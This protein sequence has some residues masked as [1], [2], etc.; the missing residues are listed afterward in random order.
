MLR[1]SS[2]LPTKWPGFRS[3]DLR[4]LSEMA[5]TLLSYTSQAP[6]IFTQGLETAE[7]K[8]EAETHLA[9]SKANF[10]SLFDKAQHD[11]MVAKGERRLSH[12]AMKGALMIFYF[13]SVRSVC[14]VVFILFFIF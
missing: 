5:C 7:E 12:E 11:D 8:A 9:A 13:R 14:F 4:F 3:V 10:E 1:T 6:L 2:G